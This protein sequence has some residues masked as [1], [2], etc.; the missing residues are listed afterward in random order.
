MMKSQNYSLTVSVM[1]TACLQLLMFLTMLCLVH[2]NFL[3][4]TQETYQRVIL[5]KRMIGSL[6]TMLSLTSDRIQT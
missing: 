4:I 2:R 1:L 3:L 6:M 5:P